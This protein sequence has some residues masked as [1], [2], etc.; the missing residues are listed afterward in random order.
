MGSSD[1]GKEQ[2]MA[3]TF[4]DGHD[5]GCLSFGSRCGPDRSDWHVCHPV[6]SQS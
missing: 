3:E 6:R 5:I 1:I 4:E 2:C